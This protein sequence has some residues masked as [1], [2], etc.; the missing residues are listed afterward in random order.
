MPRRDPGDAERLHAAAAAR[1][2][3][4]TAITSGAWLAARALALLT[5]VLL[6]RTLPAED[7]GALLAAIAAGLL[8][9]TL[10][11]GGLPDAATRSAASA[12]EGGGFGRGDLRSALIRFG[13][14]C[15]VILALL[16]AIADGPRGLDVEQLV[17]S[18]LLA[19]T[20]GGTSV[21]ASV[22]RARG[23]AGLYALVSGLI[24]AMGRVLVA[25]AAAVLDA[26]ADLVLWSFVALNA[27]VIAGVWGAA[28]RG[29]PRTRSHGPGE[30]ALHLGGAVWALL[31][32]LDVVVVGVVLGADAA[33]VYGATLRLAEFSYQVLLAVTV[34]YLPEA[35]RLAVAG[36]RLALVAL[37]RT[38]SRWSALV[39]VALAGVG[40]V[41]APWLAELLFPD[42]ASRSATLMRI[43]FVGYAAYGALGLG[44][45]TS[46]ALGEYRAIR[47]AATLA[48]PAVVVV[49]VAFAELWGAEGAACAT[50]VG[51]VC[52]SGWWIM[53]TRS[54][55]GA[56]P[57]DADYVRALAAC[58]LSL[59]VGAIVAMAM[60]DTSPVGALA[61]IGLATGVAWGIAALALRAIRPAELRALL[62]RLRGPGSRVWR[63]RRDE[64]RQP[65]AP[66]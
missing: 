38:S 22:F 15:P 21:M 29:L 65:A 2:G 39:C 52:F 31:A 41:A 17:A 10:A 54:A 12:T 66:G 13:L 48:L 42:D 14:T 5:L 36:R 23:Q 51:Y 27:A 46:V 50:A 53:R 56:T 61:A 1:V 62:R 18:G 4:G 49:T 47:R 9:A 32:H 59:A 35:T 37:Y 64:G 25:V 44:Y 45:L 33:G 55:L 63:D 30:G 26:N 7:L 20:Q 19:V 8:G 11:T 16:A 57:F 34:L 43:L 6:A 58:G 28:V 3:M 60:S 24:V 40:F